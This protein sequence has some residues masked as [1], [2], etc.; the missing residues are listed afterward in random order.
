[1]A[2]GKKLL[3]AVNQ[4]AVIPIMD[5]QKAAFHRIR[6]ETSAGFDRTITFKKA[7]IADPGV[8]LTPLA[9]WYKKESDGSIAS[10][11]LTP[12]ASNKSEY[13]LDGVGGQVSV[14]VSGGTTGTVDVYWS[15]MNG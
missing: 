9:A 8:T 3:L 10:A 6:L 14:E 5:T 13:V 15:T 7:V 12:G 11:P 1:M 2:T 4:S